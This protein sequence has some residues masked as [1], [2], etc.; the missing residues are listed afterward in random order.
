VNIVLFEPAEAAA[1][2]IILGKHDARAEHLVKVLHKVEGGTFLAGVIGG[3]RGE[4]RIDAIMPDGALTISLELG[5]DA[6]PRQ[7]LYMAV[8]FPRQIQLRRLLRD[9]SSM[10]VAAVSLFPTEYGEKS[11]LRTRLLT[12]GGARE[13]LVE[14]AAQSRDTSLPGLLLFES[15][16]EWLRAERASGRSLLAADWTGTEPHLGSLAGIAFPATLAIGNERGF[17]PREREAL[18]AAGFGR[19]SLGPR[20]LR[21]E[22]ACVAGAALALAACI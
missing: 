19:Y 20:A 7:S 6:P 12:D 21:T 10:G 11:Y 17:S 16:S 8:G 2:T 4:G 1:G 9:L 22:T 13:A 5:E 3:K 18:Q 14:G 15:F